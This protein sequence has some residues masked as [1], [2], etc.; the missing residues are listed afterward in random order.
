MLADR[1]AGGIRGPLIARVPN[2]AMYEFKKLNFDV[3]AATSPPALSALL[4]FAPIENIL[5][6]TDCPYGKME[7]VIAGLQDY[8]LTAE[9]LTAIESV[10]ARA[11]LH[12]D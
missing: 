11:L 1:I 8:G 2:G 10:N 7:K 3:A 4:R 6:G 9:Q 5:F 12:L